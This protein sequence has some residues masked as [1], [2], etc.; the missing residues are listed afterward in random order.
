MSAMVQGK[1]DET[2]KNSQLNDSIKVSKPKWKISCSSETLKTLMVR[3]I[4]P[5]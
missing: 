4:I 5:N 2:F 3:I 1:N